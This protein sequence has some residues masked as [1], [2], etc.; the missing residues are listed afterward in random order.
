MFLNAPLLYSHPTPSIHFLH[1]ILDEHVFSK[2]WARLIILK[3]GRFL[4]AKI[5]RARASLLIK[6]HVPTLSFLIQYTVLQY[7]VL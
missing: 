5:G 2:N 1:V 7:T 3:I 6:I 4:I